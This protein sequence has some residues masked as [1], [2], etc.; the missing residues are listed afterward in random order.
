VEGEI[1]LNWWAEAGP[2]A[3]LAWIGGF[4]AYSMLDHPAN[5]DRVGSPV[6]GV[7]GA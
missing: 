2:L 5:V 7:A 1:F 6:P 3:L 4:A